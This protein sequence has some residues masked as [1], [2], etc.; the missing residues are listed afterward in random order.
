MFSLQDLCR[1]NTFFLPSDF[2]KHTLHLLGLYWKGHGS[3]QR[4]K[5]DGVLIEHDLTL[6]INEAL[7]LAGEEGNNEVVK[8]LLLWEG[9]LHYA[10]IGALR[11]ENYNLVCE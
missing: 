3:I 8:L 5:N 2:S 4:I 9:N 11:T 10:I 6:S 1:K 7:I